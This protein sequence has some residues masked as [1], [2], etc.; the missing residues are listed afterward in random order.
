V[1]DTFGDRTLVRPTESQVPAGDR[2]WSMFRMSGPGG[3]R[4][5]FLFVPPPLGGPE[6]AED[7]EEVLFA[8]DE[9][10]AMGWAIE[11]RL[12]GP[13]DQPVDGHEAYLTRLAANPPPEPRKA[14]EGGPLVEYVLGTTVPDNWIPLVPVTTADRGFL[15]RRGLMQA[16]TDTLGVFEDVF[17]RGEILEPWDEDG[18]P[19]PFY[20]DEEAIPRSGVRVSR[21]FR[22]ARTADGA[23]WLWTGRRARTGRGEATSGLEWDVVRPL[24]RPGEQ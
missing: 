19:H 8:R 11:C 12:Q 3:T 16:P 4:S 23:T 2:P 21:R 18:S 13:L 10:A 15:F 20:V 6:D 17:A 1:T 9:M 14:V 22:R 5:D 24:G 7:L